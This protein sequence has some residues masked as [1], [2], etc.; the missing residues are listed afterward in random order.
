MIKEKIISIYKENNIHTIGYTDLDKNNLSP[1]NNREIHKLE[2]AKAIKIERN[3]IIHQKNMKIF[4][5]DSLISMNKVCFRIKDSFFNND[6]FDDVILDSGNYQN[7]IFIN[8]LFR[9]A[10]FQANRFNKCFFINCQFENTISTDTDFDNNSY[11]NT[12]VQE[13]K[14]ENVKS[15]TDDLLNAVIINDQSLFDFLECNLATLPSKEIKN[16]EEN[17]MQEKSNKKQIKQ[18]FKE[19][20]PALNGYEYIE[21]T[22]E[23][24]EINDIQVL[25]PSQL[26]ECHFKNVI[27]SNAVFL[28]VYFDDSTFENCQ[29]NN[30]QFSRCSFINAF[31]DNDSH[32][33]SVFF[34]CNFASAKVE[35]DKKYSRFDQTYFEENVVD[36]SSKSIK[37]LQNK[38]DV[39]D[40]LNEVV[41]FLLSD[42][43]DSSIEK[44]KPE[45]T[46]KDVLDYI[47]KVGTE[48]ALSLISSIT[49]H[50]LQAK[51]DHIEK[52]RINVDDKED[53][54]I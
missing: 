16:G 18:L 51:T 35:C 10:V 40:R 12:N 17:T 14:N 37:T 4:I 11:I 20:S 46:E 6:L 1:L 25:Y 48:V 47:D 44:P 24:M 29:F 31:F 23:N 43:F 7:C 39:I 45:T 28:E 27:F 49:Q 22:F 54:I 26:C 50:M 33:E 41:T 21:C 42:D 53:N 3:N 5:E 9:N 32:L 36:H 30:C 38:Q 2:K 34:K 8:C 19:T 52:E 13:I 15:V